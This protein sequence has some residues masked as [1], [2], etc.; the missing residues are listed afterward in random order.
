[1][2]ESVAVS[3]DGVSLSYA[4]GEFKEGR[5]WLALIIPFGLRVSVAK[6]FFDFFQPQYNV[7]SWESRLILA[8]DEVPSPPDAF[9][10][11]RHVKDFEVVLTACSIKKCIL[12]G[13]CSGAGIALG[14]AN[15]YPNRISSLAL[16]HGEYV[17][18][19]E[20]ECST[21]FAREID[22]L[23]TMAHRDEN[24][25]RQIFEKLQKD[26]LDA[27]DNRPDGIDLPFS[28]LSYLRRHAQ[29]YQSYKKADFQKLARVVSHRTLLM[30]G[31]RDAQANVASTIKI[32]DIL[33]N[34]VL[35]VDDQADHYGILRE[36]SSTLITLWND[37]V[38][39]RRRY[40]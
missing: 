21:P 6:P 5:P 29:N 8:P 31:K 28:K 12:V 19:N 10:L 14:A 37:L 34:S 40:A 22:S 33:P 39:Q 15:R 16:V 30:S 7:V 11:S 2:K 24:H 23:L 27:G 1:M 3:A 38:E 13:Y 25:L 20:P 35:H 9:E 36:D 4:V 18:L 17:L 32:K 26:R